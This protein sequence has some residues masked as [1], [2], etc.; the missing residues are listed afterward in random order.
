MFKYALTLS[1]WD[2]FNSVTQSPGR[3]DEDREG[4]E[5]DM[6]EKLDTTRLS[7]A[8]RQAIG[9]MDEC[10]AS[11]QYEANATVWRLP[12][13]RHPETE[14]LIPC[15]ICL[16]GATAVRMGYGP[17]DTW[18]P[19]E[20]DEDV[21]AMLGALNYVRLGSVGEALN[22]LGAWTGNAQTAERAQ[23]EVEALGADPDTRL[24]GDWHGRDR[25]HFVAV[26]EILERHGL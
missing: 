10:L 16:A 11:G 12:A 5:P 7:R 25:A 6:G 2:N 3:E 1:I 19:E 18:Q 14:E 22:L 15:Q 13:M 23:G 24:L 26:A 4:R 21:N 17:R 20:V 8:L 9:D